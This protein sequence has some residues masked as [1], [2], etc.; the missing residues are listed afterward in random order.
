MFCS[1]VL[2]T[3]FSSS[4]RHLCL[5]FHLLPLLSPD[6]GS[7]T[8]LRV[9]TVI[10]YDRFFDE[11]NWTRLAWRCCPKSV[12]FGTIVADLLDVD[13]NLYVVWTFCDQQ[14]PFFHRQTFL[15]CTETNDTSQE[16]YVGIS[17][18]LK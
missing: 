10:R 4:I 11:E 14:K 13:Y 5:F 15:P 17:L 7:T 16:S 3:R 6:E 12:I 2:V 18:G 9:V 1:P 8:I